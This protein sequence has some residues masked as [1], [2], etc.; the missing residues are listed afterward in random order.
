MKL[1]SSQTIQL[2]VEVTIVMQ[3][4]L[5]TLSVPKYDTAEL[6]AL[7]SCWLIIIAKLCCNLVHLGLRGTQ[8]KHFKSEWVLWFFIDRKSQILKYKPDT[9]KQCS[10]TAG[11]LWSVSAYTKNIP[12]FEFLIMLKEK[13]KMC[14]ARFLRY[15]FVP[16]ICQYRKWHF[17]EEYSL[18]KIFVFSFQGIGIRFY[19]M[20]NY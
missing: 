10:K 1:I 9:Y 19:V 5:F 16:N 17:S 18:R 13:E 12:N 14:C 15:T 2:S 6:L 3:L 8:W 11:K 7:F 20:L 4:Y